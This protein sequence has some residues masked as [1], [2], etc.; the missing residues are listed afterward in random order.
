MRLL[1]PL[2]LCGAGF[3]VGL[4]F[5]LIPRFSFVGAA[6][7]TVAS[8]WGLSLLVLAVG[9]RIYPVPWDWRRIVSAV[10]LA[11]GL[12]LASLAVD[13]WVPFAV[14]VPVRVAIT[15]AYPLALLATGF[16]PAADLA[17]AR[18]RLRRG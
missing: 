9:Q 15:A 13:A 17:A 12:A 10:G 2:A 4:Y 5:V 16:F 1:P 3:A 18:R 14:S 8:L 7:A 6:W 11:F